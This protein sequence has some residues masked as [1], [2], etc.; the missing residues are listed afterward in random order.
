MSGAKKVLVAEVG[1]GNVFAD[2]GLPN[3]QELNTKLRLCVV[4]NKILAERKLTQAE[5][6][7]ILGI[8]QPKARSACSVP[9][10]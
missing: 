2:L 7:R 10:R 9:F 1:S 8:N 5:A 4:I 6:A 3:A